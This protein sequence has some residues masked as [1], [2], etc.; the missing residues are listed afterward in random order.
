M[1]KQK[2]SENGDTTHKRP[3]K[4][5][6]LEEDDQDDGFANSHLPPTHEMST[7]EITWEL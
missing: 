1:I 2:E 4:V 7:N 6:S 5:E 3:S